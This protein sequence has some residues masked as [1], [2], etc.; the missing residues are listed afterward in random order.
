MISSGNQSLR[1]CESVLVRVLS[2]T[3]TS[4]QLG[5]DLPAEVEFQHCSHMMQEHDREE[6]N[7]FFSCNCMM[8]AT[9][10]RS[11]VN[12]QHPYLM[13]EKSHGYTASIN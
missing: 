7:I 6:R 12:F 8:A 11:G 10:Q 2:K 1:M 3:I 4:S 5:I 13:L 9:T